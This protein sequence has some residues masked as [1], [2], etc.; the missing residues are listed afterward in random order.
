[1][2]RI[3]IIIS[4]NGADSAGKTSVASQLAYK[5]KNISIFGSINKYNPIFNCSEEELFNW[6][7]VESSCDE[8]CKTIY[9]SLNMRNEDIQKSESEITIVDK[10]IENFDVRVIATLMVKGLSMDEA[11]SLVSKQKRR[12]DITD[13]EDIK[14]LFT[15]GDNINDE[16][17]NMRKRLKFKGNKKNE[18]IYMRYQ[19]I[20]RTIM[21]NILN[22]QNYFEIDTLKGQDITMLNFERKCNDIGVVLRL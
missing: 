10:G 9:S 14:M 5:Y 8:F 13:I 2:E 12:Y 11:I 1:M 19:R 4:L 15:M 7:F 3:N 16:L 6:W 20:Q 17:K 21:H 18:Q 22:K